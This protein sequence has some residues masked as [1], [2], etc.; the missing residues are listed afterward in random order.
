MT[1]FSKN[2]TKLLCWGYLFYK[3]YNLHCGICIHLYN[4]Y[5]KEENYC[6]LKVLGN[7]NQKSF[8]FISVWTRLVGLP[9]PS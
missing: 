1:A 3:H 9:E 5:V 4:H 8:L 2:V 6:I 7:I